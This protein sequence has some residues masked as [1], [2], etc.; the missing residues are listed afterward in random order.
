MHSVRTALETG[1]TQALPFGAG[2]ALVFPMVMRARSLGVITSP[3]IG[4]RAEHADLA[5]AEDLARA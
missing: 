3:A 1:H 2:W 5:L 4:R